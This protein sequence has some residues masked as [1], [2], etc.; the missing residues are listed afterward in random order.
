MLETSETLW[1]LACIT[2]DTD[3]LAGVQGYMD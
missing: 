1:L 2:Y 3:M